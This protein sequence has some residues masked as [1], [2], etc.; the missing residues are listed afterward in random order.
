MR[1]HSL[2][3]V[4]FLCLTPLLG[5]TELDFPQ[6]A[7][8]GNPAYETVLQILNEVETGNAVTIDIF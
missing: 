3:L 5:Q 2:I 1:H 4:F 7:V 6:M 8:G